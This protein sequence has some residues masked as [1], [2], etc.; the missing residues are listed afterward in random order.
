MTE[1]INKSRLFAKMAAVIAATGHIPKRGHNDFHNYD[2]VTE[3]DI[4]DA[5]RTHMAAQGIA[6]FASVVSTERVEMKNRKGDALAMMTRVT[7][8]MVFACGETGATMTTRGIGESQDDYDKGFYKAY[9]GAIKYGLLKTFL[10]PTGDDLEL[11]DGQKEERKPA[12]RQQPQR[13]PQPQSPP[14]SAGRPVN[15]QTGEI[16][17]PATQ[18]P[19]TGKG[20]IIA[21]F[22]AYQRKAIAAGLPI[23]K[24]TNDALDKLT[25]DEITVLIANIR[26]GLPPDA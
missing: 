15:P 11:D 3:A 6:F 1:G 20:A 18:P 4:V 26:K 8:E 17:Q 9:T 16:S 10:I 24:Y 7:I 12:Q 5:L 21:T 22:R 25:N 13:P 23:E 19:T 2:Y 14:Q